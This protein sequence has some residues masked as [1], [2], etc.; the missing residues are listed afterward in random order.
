LLD[1]TGI[2]PLGELQPEQGVPGIDRDVD[3]SG[4]GIGGIEVRDR[5]HGVIAAQ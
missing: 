5:A 1:R 4:G 3:R 2:L